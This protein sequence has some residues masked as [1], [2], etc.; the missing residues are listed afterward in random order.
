MRSTHA[1]VGVFRGGKQVYTVPTR[2]VD[3]VPCLSIQAR[4]VLLGMQENHSPSFLSPPQESCLVLS[5]EDKVRMRVGR[6]LAALGQPGR[7]GCRRSVKVLGTLAA[8]VRLCVWTL[9]H[10]HEPWASALLA[11]CL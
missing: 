8:E 5:Q 9:G 11:R 7:P 4:S 2:G 3:L 6:W 1:E 10:V